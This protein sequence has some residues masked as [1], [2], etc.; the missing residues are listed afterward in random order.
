MGWPIAHIRNMAWLAVTVNV[1]LVIGL[2]PLVLTGMRS[3]PASS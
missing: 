2:G 3:S 1:L